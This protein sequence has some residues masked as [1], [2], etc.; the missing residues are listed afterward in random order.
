[1]AAASSLMGQPIQQTAAEQDPRAPS[2][3]KQHGDPG[4]AQAPGE[5]AELE[6]TAHR[7]RPAWLAVAHG[8]AL[9][10][11]FPFCSVRRWTSMS[12]PELMLQ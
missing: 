10:T 5:T 4:E 6:I 11:R 3:Q 2:L 8:Q 1:M 12:H 9:S 7:P